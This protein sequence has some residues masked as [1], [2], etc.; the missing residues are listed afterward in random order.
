[1]SPERIDDG[2]SR[3]REAWLE[4]RV[5]LVTGGSK[6]IG[7]ATA[8]RF[9]EAG[10][11]GV[12]ILA[13]GEEHL[14][15][16]AAEINERAGRDAALTIA[17]DVTQE[18]QIVSAFEQTLRRFGDLHIVV[19]NAGGATSGALDE[20][21][22]DQWNEIMAVHATAYFL[23]AREAV[24]TF[25][26]LSHGGNIIFVASDNGVKPGK[27][28]LAYNAAK[29]AELHMARCIAEEGGPFGIRI[30]SVLPGAVFGRS[31]FWT[32]ELR[33]QRA[34]LHGFDPNLLEQE[35]ARHTALGVTI[36]PEEVAE[37]IA[38]LV[39]DLACKT[40]GAAFSIDGGG[41]TGYVR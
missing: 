4:D 19:S 25:K 11:R 22:L 1:M 34:A 18:V 40:T 29:A 35:Y 23:V 16:A 33:E 15:G 27:R 3:A 39:S 10:V 20:T 17:C 32:P 41:A 24:R 6:G 28:F 13:R 37:A 5:A 30:N 21:S 12:A 31:E 7:L 9:A 8:L 38:F 14:A 2:T 36:L 26:R